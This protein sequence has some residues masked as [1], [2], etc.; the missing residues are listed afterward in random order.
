MPEAAAPSWA[1]VWLLVVREGGFEPPQVTLLD[2]KSSASTRFRHSRGTRGYDLVAC[3]I[4]AP[5]TMEF[6]FVSG[7]SARDGITIGTFE[8][9]ST[10]AFCTPSVMK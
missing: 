1:S 6:L 10:P 9:T 3:A 7:P 2:P 8:P 5:A 4:T